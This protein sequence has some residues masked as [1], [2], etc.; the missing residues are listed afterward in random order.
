MTHPLCYVL[1]WVCLSYTAVGLWILACLFLRRVEPMDSILPYLGYAVVFAIVFYVC[2]KLS[3]I[4]NL[5]LL[6]IYFLWKIAYR[7]EKG[8][9]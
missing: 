7:P 8:V 3:L 5:L 2:T 4:E 6:G 9:S 1:L